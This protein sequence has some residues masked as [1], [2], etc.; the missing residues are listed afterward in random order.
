NEIEVTFT[1]PTTSEAGVRTYT[2]SVTFEGEDYTDDMKV[3]VPVLP[4]AAVDEVT[5][6]P[7]KKQLV[8]A[9]GGLTPTGDTVDKLGAAYL[10]TALEPSPETLAYYG[11]WPCDYRVTFD[12][13]L[14]GGS[15]GLYGSYGEYDLAFVYPND[16]GTDPILLMDAI[17]D[18][19]Y[20]DVYNV[21]NPFTCG[22][23][24]LSEDNVGRTMTVELIITNPDD[25]TEV[26]A[27]TSTTYTFGAVS[28]I[29]HT[30][31]FNSDGGSEVTAQEVNHGD[32]ATRPAEDPTRANYV[33]ENWYFGDSEYNFSTPVTE[34]ITLTAHW[35]EAVAKIGD[36]YYKTLKDAVAAVTDETPTTIVMIGN[37]AV[38]VEG[39]AITIAAG[40]NIT[41]D[42]NGFEVVGNALDES[43]SALI[44]NLGT[45]TVTD[46]SAEETGKLIG[47]ADHTWTWDGSDDYTGS[48]ASNLIRNEGVLTVDGGTLYNASTGSA[49]YAIDN[50]S[51]GKVTVNGG[52]VDAK[53]ASAIRMFYNNG[54]EVTVNGG[55][56]GHYVSD[57]DCSYMGIQ[58]MAG[59]NAVVNVTDGTVSGM[60][61]LYSNGTD[62]SSVSISGGLFDGYVAL[63]SAGPDNVSISGGFFNEWVGT[64]GDQTGF[65][66]GG[67]F[68]EELDPELV[69]PDYDCAP[70]TDAD[71]MED[72]PFV[73]VPS[74][75]VTLRNYTGSYT[76]ATVKVGDTAFD[77]GEEDESDVEMVLRYD[78]VFT[79]SCENACAIAWSVDGGETYTRMYAS[80]Y[81]EATGTCTFVLP[82]EAGTE[83]VIIAVVL[84]GDL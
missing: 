81:D 39:Y 49:A 54:G 72:Y 64:W 35:T 66:T 5:P 10:F 67:Y 59:T 25:A 62:D 77:N 14:A 61:A 71:T 9:A 4:I 65:I 20:S 1:A 46:G 48:Y 47:G 18:V 8:D 2:A 15:F 34:N 23:F 84:K 22:V 63:G 40:R 28:H 74:V 30:V 57:D 13:E 56:I 36:V 37:D 75:K 12:G 52:T 24:N 50:Y 82:A 17:G 33:F 70:N 79:V 53:K 7:E 42:L 44:R 83:N 11:G 31:T 27:L 16:A 6:V 41:I 78:G 58:V 55:Q 51:A 80:E 69:H 76:R 73:V 21:V 38:D 19:T 45:L 29:V 68:A 26:Y 32:A 60:Y 43:T 3:T